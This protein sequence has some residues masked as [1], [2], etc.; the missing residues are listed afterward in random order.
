MD[1]KKILKQRD[2]L[3]LE[4]QQRRLVLKAL[5]KTNF[6]RPD[7]YRLNC[8]GTYYSEHAYNGL[9]QKLFLCGVQKLRELY[10]EQFL[11]KGDNGI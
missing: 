6:R 7:A 10:R 11:N 1:L 4:T 5:I 3:N 8:E 9:V 2:S